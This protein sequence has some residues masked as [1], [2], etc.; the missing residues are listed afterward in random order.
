MS[1]DKPYQAK[2]WPVIIALMSN[3]VAHVF[4]GRL[5]ENVPSSLSQFPVGVYQSQDGGGKNDDYISMN[6]W[7]GQITVRCIDTT[8]SGAWNKALEVAQ[9]VLTISSGTYD[10]SVDISR[11][12]KFPVEKLTQGSIYTAGLVVTMGIYKKTV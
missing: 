5:S 8:I 11:P 3:H 1:Y 2:V 6:G 4:D 12:I 9:A 10:I 7:L